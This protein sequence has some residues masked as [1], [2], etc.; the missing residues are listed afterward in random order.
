ML[1]DLQHIDCLTLLKTLPDGSVDLILQDPP[2]NTTA[3][4]WEYELNFTE[5]WEQWVRVLKPNG[6]CVFTCNQPF[7]TD[8]INSNRKWFKY[9]WIW[10]KINQGNPFVAPYRPLPRHENI[11]VFG[12][13]RTTYNPQRKFVARFGKKSANGKNLNES[14]KHNGGEMTNYDGWYNPTT[15]LEIKKDSQNGSKDLNITIHPTQKPVELMRYLV[16]TYTNEG[17]TV[18]DGYSGSGTTAL[19][20][21][22]EKRNF[23]GAELNK[24]YYD[25]SINRLE[26]ARLQTSL[27]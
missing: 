23:I 2:Y 6:A 16:L 5:L 1:L 3:N 11:L 10:D 27:F 9:E 7:T 25:K 12:N 17:E 22:I 13:G 21:Q 18:F 26:M 20:C 19:A 15:I 24:E 4:E 8:L 14:F